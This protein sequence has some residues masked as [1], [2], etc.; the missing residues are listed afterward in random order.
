MPKVINRVGREYNNFCIIIGEPKIGKN[1]WIGYFTV[2]DGSGGLEI[3]EHCSIASGVHIYTH[4]SVRWAI[5]GLE[6]DH[7][8][9]THVD[10]APVKIGNNVYIGANAVICKG[11]TIEDRA[12]VAAGAVVLERT[13]IKTGE[14]WAGVPARKVG[15]LKFNIDEKKS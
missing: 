3:G 8:N 10:R 5:Q 14:I 7:E 2:I 11:V 12:V 4:D 9:Y 15:E 13:R 1:T 6:K